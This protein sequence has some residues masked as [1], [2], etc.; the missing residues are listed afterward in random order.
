MFGILFFLLSKD[1]ISMDEKRSLCPIPS[2]GFNQY[3]SGTFTDSLDLYYS[4]NF[5]FR[6]SLISIA[7]IIK[8]NKGYKGEDIKYFT[9]QNAENKKGGINTN[10]L[11]KNDTIN[12]ADSMNQNDGPYESIKSVVVCNKRAIQCFGGSRISAN[13]FAKLVKQYKNEFSNSV[14]IHCMAI[15]IGGDFYL[16]NAINKKREKE[17]IDYLYSVLAPDANCIK[18]YE[19]L[20]KHTKEY[21]QFN[22]DH[23]WTGLGAYYAYEAFC[24][25]AGLNC[26]PINY[27]TR[28]VIPEFLGT[29]YYYTRSSELKENKDSVVYFKVP[30]A[31]QTY[32]YKSGIENGAPSQ[33]YYERASG[34][35]SYGVFL[36]SD[37]PMMRCITPNKNGKKIIIFKDS[38]GNA[39]SPYLTTNFEEVIILDYRYFKGSVKNIVTKYGVTDILFAHNVYVLNSSFAIKRELESLGQ[40]VKN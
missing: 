35:N 13:N 4:D 40:N 33:L 1:K 7:G 29:L 27:F 37:Y 14:N 26:L 39:F 12:P 18:A 16:P 21:I 3:K 5:V 25:S 32:M 11:N 36:G 8:E 17:F 24:K 9:N 23:H 19:E 10:L 34:G 38:Y 28:K 31:T 22:T 6:N 2:F 20:Q 15:P 30:F